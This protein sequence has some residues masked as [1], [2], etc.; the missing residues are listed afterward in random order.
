MGIAFKLEVFLVDD[1]C[2]DGTPEAIRQQFPQVTIIEGTGNLF[3]NRGMHKAWETAANT[4][5]FDYYLCLNDDTFLF[6]NAIISSLNLDYSNAVIV[7]TTHSLL[8]QKPTYGGRSSETKTIIRPNGLFQK[9]YLINGNFLLI[10]KSVYNIIGKL[11]PIFTHA[12]GD[13][14]YYFRGKKMGIE[15]YVAPQ[16]VGICE[17]HITEFKDSIPKWRSNSI[18]VITRLKLLYQPQSGCNPKQFFIYKKRHVG[19]F[20]GIYHF[21]LLHIR[22]IFPNLWEIKSFLNIN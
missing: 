19:L 1:G 4:K 11:D 14:D 10:S 9:C 18:P 22:C 16:Y 20:S 2:T 13:F 15:F 3:W 7:G 17:D 21:C 5:D 8:N 6:K 12:L